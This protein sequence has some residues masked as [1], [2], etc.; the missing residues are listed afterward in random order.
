MED[1][2][3]FLFILASH[4]LAAFP[5]WRRMRSGKM[6]TV[7][8]FAVI[9][10]VLYYDSGIAIEL[11]GLSSQEKFF[12]SFFSANANVLAQAV[13]LLIALPWLFRLGSIIEK[14]N[15]Y[16]RVG[17]SVETTKISRRTLFYTLVIFF[18]ATTSYIG[19]ITL[20]QGSAIWEVRAKVSQDLGVMI[21]LLYLPIYFLAFYI[22]KSDSKTKLGLFFCLSLILASILSTGGIGQRTTI[23]IPFLILVI[24]RNKVSPTKLIL[25]L[26]IGIISASM[27]LPIFKGQYSSRNDSTTDLVVQTIQ[28]DISRSNV[29]ISALERTEPMGTSL[30]PYPLSGYVYSLL[31]FIPRQI[32]PFKG[33]STAQYFTSDIVGTTLEETN[34]GFGIGVVE[35][36]LLNVGFWLSFPL[37]LVY[38]VVISK[39]DKLSQ[40]MPSL[41][42]P[43][44][45][46]ALW[47]CGYNLP[48]LLLMFGSMA[49]VCLA[50]HYVFGSHKSSE[51]A[52]I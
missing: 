20:S 27:L 31:F 22:T 49:L 8:D 6:L 52:S 46:S 44:R 1:I 40:R 3:I 37:L 50:L 25:F 23:L 13:I 7:A 16:K 17:Q 34:W 26:A 4:T 30:L 29:L 12:T 18:S 21:I 15:T 19:Y 10:A 43:T 32:A 48:S 39:L 5:A 51:Q 45:L 28:F 36:V 24:F 38:G 41:I 11:L 9:S 42:V 33:Q 2:T 35:E 14:K 47:L